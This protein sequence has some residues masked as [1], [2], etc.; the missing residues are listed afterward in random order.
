MQ[1]SNCPFWDWEEDLQKEA[2]CVII[3]AVS[4]P[5]CCPWRPSQVQWGG[6]RKGSG[7]ED[8]GSR[9]HRDS[10]TMCD[11]PSLG[12]AFQP[13]TARLIVLY[14][15]MSS[16]SGSNSDSHSLPKTILP[17]LRIPVGLNVITALPGP[18]SLA[19]WVIFESF[20]SLLL[21]VHQ[22]LNASILSAIMSVIL[23]VFSFSFP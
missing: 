12:A 9:G 8:P 11:S 14:V 23:R 15:C 16:S 20:F 3:R 17:S 4:G 18:Q 2:H 13:W 5:S 21:Q 7:G 22:P 1:T 10:C 19:T 6:G